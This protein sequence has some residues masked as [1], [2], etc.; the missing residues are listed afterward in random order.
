MSLAGSAVVSEAFNGLTLGWRLG[1]RIGSPGWLSVLAGAGRA[2][3]AAVIMGVTVIFVH[4]WI[5]QAL[6]NH[7]AGKLTQFISVGGAIGIGMIVYLLASVLLCRR[8]AA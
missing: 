3:I 8:E 7:L 6:N 1:R 5:F 4:G 2:L